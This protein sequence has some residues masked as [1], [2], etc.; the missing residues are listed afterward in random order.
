MTRARLALYEALNGQLLPVRW[1]T[2]RGRGGGIDPPGWLVTSRDNGPWSGR[3][4]ANDPDRYI[5]CR[6]TQRMRGSVRRYVHTAG[7]RDACP[8]CIAFREAG[9][10]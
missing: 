3:I 7:S 2:Q 6:R 4:V 5:V 8:E 1:T 10:R 9:G